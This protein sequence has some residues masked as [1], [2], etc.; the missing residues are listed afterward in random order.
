M[1]RLRAVLSASAV[2]GLF[3]FDAPADAELPPLHYQKARAAADTVLVMDIAD[4]LLPTKAFSA[5]QCTV[6]GRVTAVERGTSYLSG[7]ELV[8]RVPCVGKRWRPIPGSFKG[9]SAAALS[10]ATRGR[11]YLQDG[12]VVARGYDELPPLMEPQVPDCSGALHMRDENLV[13]A[14]TADVLATWLRR[15]EADTHGQLSS[16]F[17]SSAEARVGTSAS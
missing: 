13:R 4:V 3:I 14:S 12:E 6:S 16:R 1:I 17:V 11:F 10:K 7:D 9:Y 5:A 8:V 15:Q 2:C